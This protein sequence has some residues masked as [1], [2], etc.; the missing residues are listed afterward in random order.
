MDL[1]PYQPRTFQEYRLAMK[2][3]LVGKK[4]KITNF[5]AGSRVQTIFDSIAFLLS[6]SD[7]E[8]MMGFKIALLE[9][10]YALFGI[11][12]LPGKKAVGVL[13]IEVIDSE[14]LLPATFPIFN[15]S[16]ENLTFTTETDIVLGV[17]QDYV[18]VSCQ[19]DTE[20]V[21]GNLPISFIDSM[22]G[23]SVFSIQIPDGL[24]IYNPTAFMNGEDM[25]T[26][27]A[28]HLRFQKFINSLNRSTLNAVRSTV[29]SIKNVYLCVVEDNVNPY[30]R[31]KENGWV[32]VYI[33]DGT[34]APSQSLLDEIYKI[35]KGD[36]NDPINYPGYI[37]AGTQLYVGKMDVVPVEVVLKIY[38]LSTTKLSNTQIQLQVYDS[39]L[40]YINGLPNGYNV[41][42][43][44]LKSYA[45]QSHPDIYRVEIIS[46]AQDVPISTL[47]LPRVGGSFG[48]RVVFESI[49]KVKYE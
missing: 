9:G 24:R 6:Q 38:V 21:D 46:P 8:T 18:E 42:V 27:D 35:L 41:L 11:Y 2:N 37:S 31:T 12:T 10:L 19:C 14:A 23:Q 1:T 15:V 33:S 47:Q 22:D 4:S 25:E 44:T 13:R 17:G 28:K 30:T 34:P 45:I 26:N 16:I 43:D 29:V 49:T 40:K 39:I 5:N 36:L 32:N 7:L 20:G 3:W 48:G